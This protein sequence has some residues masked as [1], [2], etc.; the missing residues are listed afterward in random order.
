MEDLERM[1]EILI[2]TIK[3]IIRTVKIKGA[4]GNGFVGWKNF[5]KEDWF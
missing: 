4:L 3:H 2:E 5:R 1:L